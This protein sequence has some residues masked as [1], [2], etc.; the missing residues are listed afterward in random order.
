LRVRWAGNLIHLKSVGKSS[1]AIDRDQI[2]IANRARLRRERVLLGAT[3]ENAH[4]QNDRTAKNDLKN[5]L[6]KRRIHITGP[7][8]RNRP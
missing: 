2:L 4:G 5:G 8:E 3:D 7:D 6:K 1:L